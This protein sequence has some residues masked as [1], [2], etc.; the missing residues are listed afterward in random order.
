MRIQLWHADVEIAGNNVKKYSNFNYSGI[1]LPTTV[2][3]DNYGSET[4]SSILLTQSTVLGSNFGSVIEL[5]DNILVASVTDS[6]I[7]YILDNCVSCCTM[8][9]FMKG[10]LELE[11]FFKIS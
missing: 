3:L 4:F 11:P 5:Y 7:G 9:N 1:E 8:C 6:N 10:S 2:N